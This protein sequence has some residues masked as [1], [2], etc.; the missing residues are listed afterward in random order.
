MRKYIDH[1]LV[2]RP[3]LDNTFWT[4]S[5]VMCV[6][7]GMSSNLTE[8]KNVLCFLAENK[9]DRTQEATRLRLVPKN[10]LIGSGKRPHLKG[11]I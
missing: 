5:T 6:I 2:P 9:R 3:E 11:G 4:D 7:V 10:I 8:K 1:R